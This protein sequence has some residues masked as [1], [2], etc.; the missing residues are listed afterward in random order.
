MIRTDIINKVVFKRVHKNFA[1]S[2]SVLNQNHIESKPIFRST[3][4]SKSYLKSL[5]KQLFTHMYK[6][7]Q[8]PNFIQKPVASM[9]FTHSS[10]IKFYQST[11]PHTYNCNHCYHL[12]PKMTIDAFESELTGGD[13]CK[14]TQLSLPYTVL[15][16][17]EC[18]KTFFKI[19]CTAQLKVLM[20]SNF[21][22]D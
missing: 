14:K 2:V 6:Q 17:W 8:Q 10:P 1:C 19:I 7:N 18:R 5:L 13:F 20:Q 3:D 15:I 22:V 16:I 9:I 11:R 12:V 21:T 4:L